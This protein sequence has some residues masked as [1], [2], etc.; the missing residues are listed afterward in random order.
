MV[1]CTLLIVI[2]CSV[3]AI[4][5]YMDLSAIVLITKQAMFSLFRNFQGQ[6]KV[7]YPEGKGP[8]PLS[9]SSKETTII[10]V[11]DFQR[12]SKRLD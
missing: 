3:F 2:H 4:F 8:I 1:C 6:Q 9:H 7:D 10:C 5:K 12:K 11:S